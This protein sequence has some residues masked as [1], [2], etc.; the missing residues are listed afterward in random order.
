M[1]K[2]FALTIALMMVFTLGVF[3]ADYEVDISSITDF[4]NGC[5]S[6]HEGAQFDGVTIN[7]L[8]NDGPK[9]CLGDLNLADYSKV[10]VYY[11]SDPSAYYDI[12]DN[13]FLQDADGNNIGSFQPSVPYGFWGQA[14]RESEI[15]IS[16][17][18]SGLVYLASGLSNHGISISG[19]TF[20]EK[21][22]GDNA[23]ATDAATDAPATNAPTTDAPATN[24]PASDAPATNAPAT[25]APATNA[26]ATNASTN[27]PATDSDDKADDDKG[28]PVLPIII[29][30]AVVAVAAVVAVVLVK[31]FKK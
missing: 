28:S 29:I 10:I 1:K 27:A 19:V 24:A 14:I 30:I 23:P 6:V 16:S 8:N 17:D 5:I 15:E 13:V 20:V 3:A 26:P 25:N 18:Y 31:K 21:T 7:F 22:E 11:G 4:T 9:A 12:S 2:F